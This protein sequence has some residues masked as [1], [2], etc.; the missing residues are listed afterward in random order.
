MKRAFSAGGVI[1]YKKQNQHYYLL[2]LN[3]HKKDKEHWDFPKGLIEK[4]EKAEEAARQEIQEETG[5][6]NF[7]FIPGFR[8]DIQYFFKDN[9]DLVFKQVSYFLVRANTDQV[10][11]SWEHKGYLWLPFNE[12][13]KRLT[14]KNSQEILE[15]AEK[16]LNEKFN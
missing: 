2:L 6:T 4:G 10:K 14:H 12:A 11:I 3:K 13:K 1:F 5:L 8:K 16:F 7:D 15:A 9:K